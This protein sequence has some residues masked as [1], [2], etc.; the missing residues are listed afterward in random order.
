MDCC[1]LG[2]YHV[3]NSVP[4]SVDEMRFHLITLFFVLISSA[5]F[6]NDTL[7]D[8]LNK[9]ER[10]SYLD[11]SETQRIQY[12]E[13]AISYLDSLYMGFDMNDSALESMAFDPHTET[14]ILPPKP[15]DTDL[16][17]DT[18]ATGRAENLESK[19]ESRFMTG[20]SLDVPSVPTP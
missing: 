11:R 8:L 9:N 18:K 13:R 16:Q 19:S 12:D 6:A 20:G 5:V 17:I 1:Y 10:A 4:W 7:M 14:I 15:G 3:T 2:D